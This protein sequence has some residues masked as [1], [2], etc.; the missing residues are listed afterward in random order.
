MPSLW[1]IILIIGLCNLAAVTIGLV[2][3]WLALVPNLGVKDLELVG[4]W[5]LGV[6]FFSYAIA[7]FFYYRYCQPIWKAGAALAKGRKTAPELLEKARQSSLNFSVVLTR[8]SSYVWMLSALSF[9]PVYMI[10]RPQELIH[11]AI[12]VVVCTILVSNASFSFIYYSSEWFSQK[13]IIPHLFPDGQLSH[14]KGVEKVSTRFK[15][16]VLVATTC[17]LPVLVLCLTALLGASSPAVF[18]FLG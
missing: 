11:T 1:I 10:F 3:G 5:G 16:L 2:Y 14:V 15:I 4:L 9:I 17:A 7:P 8:I 6:L 12:Y 13:Y 18:I